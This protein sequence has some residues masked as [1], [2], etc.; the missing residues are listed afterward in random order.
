MKAWHR[1]NRN[2]EQPST[3]FRFPGVIWLQ[4][5][6]EKLV[7]SCSWALQWSKRRI[8]DGMCVQRVWAQA[9]N[10]GAIP[11]WPFATLSLC[12]LRFST[13]EPQSNLIFL[14]S[15]VTVGPW[16]RRTHM[17]SWAPPMLTN[18]FMLGAI[19][20]LPCCFEQALL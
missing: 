19:V 12:V 3:L 2:F 13:C 18:H 11:T 8:L 20:A 5:T 1:P 10:L 15:C 6:T 9:F 16:M 17:L 14:G 7:Q 4:P